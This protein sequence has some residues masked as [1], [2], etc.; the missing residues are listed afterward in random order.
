M[1]RDSP[2][3]VVAD[4]HPLFRLGVATALAA[5]GVVATGEIDN[6][7]DLVRVAREVSAALVV[8]GSVA[9]LPLAE[10]VR[11]AKALPGAPAVVVMVGG[12]AAG[13]LAG[14]LSLDT[15]AL[16]LRSAHPD[17]LCTAVDRLG[18]GERVVA[19]SLLPLLLGSVGSGAEPAA[20]PAGGELTLTKREREVLVLLAQGRSNRELASAMYVTLATV[21]THL[22]HIYGKLDASNRNEAIGRAIALGLIG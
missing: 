15:D 21:K 20:P 16:L 6:G 19:P 10:V 14:L 13:E 8:V 1:G 3:A 2:V 12:S 4:A 11:R 17:E 18:R 9:D 7:R 5:T 22:A